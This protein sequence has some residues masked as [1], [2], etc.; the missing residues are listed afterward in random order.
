MQE[1]NLN[2]IK[3]KK[4]LQNKPIYL[5]GNFLNLTNSIFTINLLKMWINRK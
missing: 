2:F 4:N 1:Q 3:K 5:D